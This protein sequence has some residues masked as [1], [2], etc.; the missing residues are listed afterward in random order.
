MGLFFIIFLHVRTNIVF[1]YALILYYGYE[2]DIKIK[3][4]H[5]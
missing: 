3:K 2:T 1:L 4:E 5:H